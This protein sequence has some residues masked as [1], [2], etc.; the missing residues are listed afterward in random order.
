MQ[1]CRISDI[2]QFDALR[3]PWNTVYTA[4][5]KATIFVSWPWLRGWIES[6][7][8][9]EEGVWYVL[10]LRPNAA[11]SFI[12]FL[13]IISHS[14]RGKLQMAGTPLADHTG[15][16]CLPGYEEEVMSIFAAFIQRQL[17]WNRFSM[18]DVYDS[19][20]E[21]F[22]EN[23]PPRAYDIRRSRGFLCPYIPLPNSWKQYLQDFLSP[24]TR[25]N[26]RSCLR[27]VESLS[28]F[29]V[30]NVRTDEPESQIEMLLTLWQ[31]RWGT[32]PERALNRYRAILHRCFE[33]G[34]LWLTILW[35]G[36]VPIAGA[37]CF[38]DR[39]K[40]VFSGF[41]NGWNNEFA[42]LSP[43]KAVI[44]YS[45]RYAIENGFRVYD[46]LR[47]DERYKLSFGATE[48]FNTDVTIRRRTLRSRVKKMIERHILSK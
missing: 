20:L 9:E 42:K 47:G 23:F 27:R 8:S 16:V 21:L 37:A 36:T 17:K 10:A 13:P 38:V 39:H 7:S 31:S 48:R 24:A 1:V 3:E 18:K 29:R 43:G 44:A 34:S 25:R 35:D 33:N 6:M 32:K 30:T 40:G 41:I 28:G 22:L 11:S 46:L 26:L 45:I 14:T 2:H 4:D 15:F 5:P 12:A 19:R